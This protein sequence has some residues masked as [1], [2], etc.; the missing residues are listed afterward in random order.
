MGHKI[1]DLLEDNRILNETQ[2]GF[3]K[4]Y[5]TIDNIMALYTLIEYYTSHK[6]K[7]F[8]CL[9]D[10]MKAFNSIWRVGLWQKLLKHWIEGKICNII[11]HMYN[12][13]KYCITIARNTSGYLTGREPITFIICNLSK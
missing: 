6:Q 9:V 3:R 4:E 7:L 12:G 11:K 13:I 5:S 10:F 1:I 2:S 8:C